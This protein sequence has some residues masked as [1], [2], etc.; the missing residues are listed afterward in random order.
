M[1][2][3][4]TRLTFSDIQHSKYSPASTPAPA[5]DALLEFVD[6]SRRDASE[7]VDHDRKGERMY[8]ARRLGY[9]PAPIEV[10][11]KIPQYERGDL[12]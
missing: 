6:T 8:Y 10:I 4:P 1:K 12:P 5:P 9:K 7:P 11:P 3:Y 2:L